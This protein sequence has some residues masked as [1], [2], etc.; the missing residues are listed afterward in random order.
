MNVTWLTYLGESSEV[1]KNL[2]QYG[3]V[4]YGYLATYKLHYRCTVLT[5]HGLHPINFNTNLE[6][7]HVR[8]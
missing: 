5:F 1:Q 6:H 7:I 8:L 3:T 4:N 2:Y